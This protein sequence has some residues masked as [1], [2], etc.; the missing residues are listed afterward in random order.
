MHGLTD[1]SV[2]AYVGR[3][4]FHTLTGFDSQPR[5][6]HPIVSDGAMVTKML[7]CT[8]HLERTTSG[9]VYGASMYF[10]R[11]FA[12]DGTFLWVS[13]LVIFVDD[14]RKTRRV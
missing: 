11:S 8:F 3:G 7:N 5:R 9:C 6:M 14:G 10:A 4:E 2:W 12:M 13:R 1:L